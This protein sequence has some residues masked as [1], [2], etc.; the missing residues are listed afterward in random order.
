[1]ILAAK[2]VKGTP[3]ALAFRTGTRILNVIL[4]LLLACAGASA[5]RLATRTYITGDGLPGN[6]IRCIRRDSRGF[7]WFCTS[8]GLARFDGYQFSSYTTDTG[9]PNRIISDLLETRDHTYLLATSDG[10][11]LFDPLARNGKP[12]FVVYR[13]GPPGPAWARQIRICA[14]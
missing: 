3:L 6:P 13:L 9:L 5:E 10:V 14:S 4:L 11:V 2:R 1:M 7:L 8:E 12:K